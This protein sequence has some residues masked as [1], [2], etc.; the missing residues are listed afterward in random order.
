MIVRLEAWCD[1]VTEDEHRWEF[2]A[3][4]LREHGI[5]VAPEQL[6]RLRARAG[7]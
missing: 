5:D 2:L 4:K 1:F 7:T 3:E 6:K